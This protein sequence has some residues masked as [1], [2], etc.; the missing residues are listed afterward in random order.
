MVK[1]N[2]T[3]KQTTQDNRNRYQPIPLKGTSNIA[4]DM[5]LLRKK[6]INEQFKG[7]KT[8]EMIN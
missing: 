4:R 8:N 3:Y 5:G 1:S 7:H 2:T 6:I